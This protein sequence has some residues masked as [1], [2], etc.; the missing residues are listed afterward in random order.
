MIYVNKITN[1]FK[2]TPKIHHYKLYFPLSPNKY[3]AC[4]L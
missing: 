1:F 4:C 3:N 2:A